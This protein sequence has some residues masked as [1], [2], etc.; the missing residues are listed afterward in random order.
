[1]NELREGLPR[2]SNPKNNGIKQF[3]LLYSIFL[4]RDSMGIR[5]ATA[6]FEQQ[7]RRFP[8]TN[9]P[10]VPEATIP[11]NGTLMFT[12]ITEDDKTGLA[13]GRAVIPALNNDA[14]YFLIYDTVSL[15]FEYISDEQAKIAEN[16][17]NY[18][19][20]KKK[21]LA[22]T[23]SLGAGSSITF[24]DGY[25]DKDGQ[26]HMG[27][28]IAGEEGLT[29]GPNEISDYEFGGDD[30]IYVAD[31]ESQMAM[32]Q[33][34]ENNNTA[35]IAR[36]ATLSEYLETVNN[37]YANNQT[38]VS[39]LMSQFAK[40]IEGT[41]L[42]RNMRLFGVPYQFTPSTDPRYSSVSNEVG[43]HFANNILIEAPIVTIIPGKPK[44]LSGDKDKDTTTTALINAAS[45]KFDA[46]KEK[47]SRN[48][49]KYIRYYDFQRAYI[50]Y[51][52]YVNILC[53]ACASFLELN[54]TLDG[55]PLTSYDW[56]NYRSDGVSYSG[57]NGPNGNV[58]D[59]LCSSIAANYKQGKT[60]YRNGTWYP[61]GYTFTGTTSSNKLSTATGISEVEAM[62]AATAYTYGDSANN[63]QEN[64]GFVYETDTVVEEDETFVNSLEN[65]LTSYNFVQFCVDPS[66]SYSES[67][68]NQTTQ[69]QIKST[70]DSGSS[71]LKELAF[72]TNSAGV[73][74]MAKFGEFADASLE[75]LS[76]HISQMSNGSMTTGLSRV[77]SVLGNI[78][79]GENIIMPDIYSSS[80][81]S[82]SYSFT[83]HLKNHY[84][85]RFGYFMEILAPLMHL[86]ALALPKQTTANTYGS[87]FLVKVMCQGLFTCNLGIVTGLSVN[88]D[89]CPEGW[90]IDGLPNEVDVTVQIADLYSDLTMSPQSDPL[91]FLNNSSLIDYLATQCGLS[92]IKPNL[93]AKLSSV[94]D[95]IG[96]AINPKETWGN[97]TGEVKEKIHSSITECIGLG[98]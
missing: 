42:K 40:T 22:P 49:S 17:V 63:L 98:G 11:A 91:L 44:Y 51:M 85:N 67:T 25:I 80:Q 48:S 88:R 35:E 70:L 2:G 41:K 68:D 54:E 20:G 94:I 60:L 39:T 71:M 93:T 89:V 32:V 12:D 14:Y 59:V 24:S 74:E 46:L 3:E 96:N 83:V 9:A 86:L 13:W 56:K 50:E 10:Q 65:L 62:R 78:L 82:K 37:F 7:G 26:F 61:G 30:V 6:K 66:I 64:K 27:D 73:E 45:G 28:L 4:R 1:M 19:L 55:V 34:K 52:R 38:D 81:F 87:P 57:T 84:G 75:S 97:I 21:P 76:S 69:S 15:W 72:V 5:Y 18:A 58:T 31:T 8:S 79:K 95:V 90:T 16:P 36:E 43:F 23:I 33:F 92:L 77:L 29:I 47:L 53:R